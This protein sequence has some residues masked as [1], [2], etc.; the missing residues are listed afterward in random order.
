ML[1][2]IEARPDQDPLLRV[3]D[4]KIIGSAFFIIMQRSRLRE[5]RFDRLSEIIVQDRRL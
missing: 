3:L 1:D 2:I 4:V 5:R